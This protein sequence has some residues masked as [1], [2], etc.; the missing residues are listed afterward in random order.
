MNKSEDSDLLWLRASRRGDGVGLTALFDTS[1][2]TKLIVHVLP[3]LWRPSR[4]PSAVVTP[5]S[6]A[7]LHVYEG[8]FVGFGSRWLSLADRRL[9]PATWSSSTAAQ[10][11]QNNEAQTVGDPLWSREIPL[12]RVPRSLGGDPG[13]YVESMWRLLLGTG[14]EPA[15]TK[16]T[17]LPSTAGVRVLNEIP[18]LEALVKATFIAASSEA[19]PRRRPVYQSTT[20][21]TDSVRGRLVVN[22]LFIRD[23]RGEAAISCEFDELTGDHHYWQVVRAALVACISS[24]GQAELV[25]DNLARLHD[26]GTPSLGQ[27]LRYATSLN[28]TTRDPALLNLLSLAVFVLSR[29]FPLASETSEIPGVLANVKFSTSSLWEVL[30]ERAFVQAG[31]SVTRHESLD[32]VY[33]PTGRGWVRSPAKH[34]DLWVTTPSG[35]QFLV[36]AKYSEKTDFTKASMSDQYQAIAYAQRTELTTLLVFTRSNRNPETTETSASEL[37]LRATP[38]PGFDAG[39]ATSH[40]L[41]DGWGL[42][43]SASFDFP[44]P[45]L[46][47][48]LKEALGGLKRSAE[49]AVEQVEGARAV[50]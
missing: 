46:I 14:Q 2:K 44:D 47:G 24:P 16:G 18:Q 37:V 33:R 4:E 32:V 10:D 28:Q 1:T 8:D 35:Q 25:M 19:I 50:R 39:R 26:V 43:G 38:P 48:D 7:T 22:D 9:A 23:L 45:S 6:S 41:S 15:L 13:K 30:L 29:D 21:R 11:A 5:D 20:Q 3:K 34:P 49:S 27:A 12:R 40:E 36:D 42:V 31:C 17:V